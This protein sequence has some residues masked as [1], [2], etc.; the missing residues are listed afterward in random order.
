MKIRGKKRKY[1]IYIKMK[2][3]KNKVQYIIKK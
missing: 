1:K 3:F 2:N